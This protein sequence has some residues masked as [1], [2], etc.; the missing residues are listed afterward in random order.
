MFE[1]LVT[2][3]ALML[4]MVLLLKS[5]QWLRVRSWPLAPISWAAQG[6]KRGKFLLRI[7][8][9]TAVTTVQQSSVHLLD[10]ATAHQVP[11]VEQARHGSCMHKRDARKAW[12]EPGRMNQRAQC[13]NSN[14]AEGEHCSAKLVLMSQF[15]LATQCTKPIA[16]SFIQEAMTGN[17]ACLWFTIATPV[18]R[19]VAQVRSSLKRRTS[20]PRGSSSASPQHYWLLVPMPGWGAA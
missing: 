10:D 5:L 14:G 17:N 9:L 6:E 15:L 11:G 3:R 12:D 16:T 7:W 13:G 19:S 18:A 1:R 2:T 20:D 4:L 8:V